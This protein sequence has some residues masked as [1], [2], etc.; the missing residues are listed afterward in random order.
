MLTFLDM[1]KLIQDY[2]TNCERFYK[3]VSTK[4]DSSSVIQI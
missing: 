3:Q 2:N 1:N 4:E